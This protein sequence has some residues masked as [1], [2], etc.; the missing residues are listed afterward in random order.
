MKNLLLSLLVLFCLSDTYAQ[1]G[2]KANGTAPISSAQL[3]VQSTTKAFYPPRMTTAQKNAI[4]GATAGAVVYD[5]DLSAL[6]YYNGSAW[7]VGGSGIT[8][9]YISSGNDVAQIYGLFRISELNAATGGSAIQGFSTNGSGLAG[10]S[11][12]YRGVYGYSNNGTAG[13]FSSPSG[14]ALITG[15]GNVGIGTP[16]PTAKLDVVRGTAPDGTAIFRGTTHVSHFN[17]ATNEDTYIRGG[18]NGSNVYINDVIG[19][20][21]VGIGTSSPLEK[22]HLALGTMRINTLG[23]SGNIQMYANDQGTII[24]QIPIAFSVKNTNSLIALAN[25]TVTTFPFSTET[26]DV[27]G[28]FDNS[29]YEFIPP[30]NGIYHFDCSVTFGNVNSTF[31]TS[32]YDL[33]ILVDGATSAD[34]QQDIKVGGYKTLNL[35]QDIKLNAGQ[36]VKITVYQNSG[37]SINLIGN[38]NSYFNGHLVVKL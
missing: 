34:S 25:A 16:T 13:Y 8:L 12:N 14:Y 19:L 33:S 28:F 18:K 21:N 3:E 20:G 31:S 1:I 2:V 7:V 17:Y 38:V 29:T 9:P 27:G 30:T 26:Y 4:A 5:T 35:S 22:L 6:N 10:S 15:T 32:I 23:G 24:G 36:K 37:N 11:T